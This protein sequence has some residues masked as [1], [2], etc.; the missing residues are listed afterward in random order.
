MHLAAQADVRVS[1]ADPAFDA[2]G[3]RARH[4]QR[5]RGRAPRRTLA[6][7]SRPRAARSTA[8]ASG[9]AREDDPCLPLSPYGAAKLAGEGYLGA[10]GAPLRRRRTSRS[11]FGNVY[12]PRQ[13][14]HGEAGVVAIFLGR[15]L[16]GERC[17]IFGDG[18]QSRDYVYVGDVARA[19]ARGARRRRRAA[20]STS[21]PASRRPCSSST[22]S[23]GR[24]PARTR[25]RSTRR[26]GPA[27]SAAAC[28]TASSPRRALGF[29]P[30]TSLAAG[31]AATWEST[32]LRRLTRAA[33]ARR[34]R[35][36]ARERRARGR[37]PPA[38]RPAD[39]AVAHGGDR[40]RRR[41]GRR[42]ARARR[43]RRRADREARRPAP[44]PVPPRRRSRASATA[45]QKP[46]RHARRPSRRRRLPR[47]SAARR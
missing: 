35:A 14:P 38:R 37:L 3:Q 19:T 15:L 41:R 34:S 5:A 12:G 23:A 6:S 32:P 33:I 25:R 4:R 29:R 47:T 27:S 21:A 36:P 46:A 16:D 28:S 17:R 1:V 8:S 44:P 11:G 30:E 18:S 7:S 26:P 9:P 42:A 39:P 2:G 45:H 31:V 40:R 13:D 10:F 22:T 20:C 24:P 43:R